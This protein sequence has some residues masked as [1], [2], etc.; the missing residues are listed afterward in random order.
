ME[1]SDVRA[2]GVYESATPT[3]VERFDSELMPSCALAGSVGRTY[4]SATL[5]AMQTSAKQLAPTMALTIA[6]AARELR[7]SPLTLRRWVKA[8]KLSG[9]WLGNR[10][11]IPRTA[12]S[13]LLDGPHSSAPA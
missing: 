7:L 10:W 1:A 8:G 5:D 4:T 11:R 13:A 6:E 9:V 2:S 3:A 12:L